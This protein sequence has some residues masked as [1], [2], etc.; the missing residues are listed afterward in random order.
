[1]SSFE[2]IRDIARRTTKKNKLRKE[3]AK[4]KPKIVIGEIDDVIGWGRRR[5]PMSRSNQSYKSG[6]LIRTPMHGMQRSLA[7]HDSEI[8]EALTIDA[9]LQPDVI[10]IECQAVTIPLPRRTDKGQDR[11]HTFDA[12]I[13]LRNGMVYL[14]YVKSEQSLKR[15]SSVPTVA[16]IVAHTPANLC[17]RVIIISDVSFTRNYR[18]NNRR[19]L[20][21]HE[22]PD[23]AADELICDLVDK[24]SEPVRIKTLI[25]KSGLRKCQAWQAV[26][27]MIGA[28]RIGAE[29]DAVIDYPSLIWRL[30]Q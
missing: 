15:S 8:E 23:P 1:M 24:L 19:I 30:E 6:M 14:V 25:E 21:C 7:L 27:R 2:E 12:R 10:G 28:R 9:L 13:T 5:N 26:M 16:E 17:D 3:A 20:M 4:R 22:M 11:S 18:D 29:R